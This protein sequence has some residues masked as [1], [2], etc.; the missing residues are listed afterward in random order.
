MTKA[1]LV[2]DFVACAVVALTAHGYRTEV[3]R[4]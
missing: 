1:R 2:V 4:V 3:W